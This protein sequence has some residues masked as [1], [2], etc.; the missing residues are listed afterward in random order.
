M[1]VVDGVG[2]RSEGLIP[3]WLVPWAR[4]VRRAQA[5]P[6]AARLRQCP[7]WRVALHRRGRRWFTWCGGGHFVRLCVGL[8]RGYLRDRLGCG[9]LRHRRGL[10][11]FGGL[12]LR[13]GCCD[14]GG[15]G[16]CARR[17]D[18]VVAF[19]LWR[20]HLRG[21]A[22]G[23]PLFNGKRLPNESAGAGIA[24]GGIGL[25]TASCSGA[26]PAASR[27]NGSWLTRK[28]ANTAKPQL[29]ATIEATTAAIK[30]RTLGN[31]RPRITAARDLGRSTRH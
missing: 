20:R 28:A 25:P 17:F 18:A 7:S 16:D 22:G 10:R 4:F 6:V 14:G 12:G 13:C 5:A 2:S 11:R 8:G 15:G 9:C 31:I 21:S 26:A 23:S 27:L 3:D 1:V 29:S 30:R 19:G 24:A